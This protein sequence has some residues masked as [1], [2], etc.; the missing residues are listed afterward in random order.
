[1]NRLVCIA[2]LLLPCAVLAADEAVEPVPVDELLRDRLDS[3]DLNYDIDEDNDFVL[4]FNFDDGRSQLVW[5]RSQVYTSHDVAM[6]DVWAYAYEHPTKHLPNS[7]ERRLLIES[8]DAIMGS[9]AREGNAIVYMV[10]LPAD[11]SPEALQAALFEA[12]ELADE[13]EKQLLGTDEL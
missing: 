7:L 11:A 10:K 13:L 6:R 8:Y 9:W 5:V 1:M 4:Q 3:L 12:S 2:L